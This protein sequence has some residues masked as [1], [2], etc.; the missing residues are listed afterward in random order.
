MPACA[1]GAAMP[2]RVVV[3][4]A[5]AVS[6]LGSSLEATWLALRAGSIAVAPITHFDA[7]G[8]ACRDA[9]VIPEHFLTEP[10]LSPREAR[11]LGGHGLA[12]LKAVRGALDDAALA[13]TGMPPERLGVFAGMGMVDPLPEDLAAAVSRS[14]GPAGLDLDAFLAEGYR[15]IHP[16]WP[17]GMLNNVAVCLVATRFG[18]LG[19]NTVLSSGP[20]AGLGA[21]L[22]AVAAVA[23]GRVQAAVAAAAAE[24]VSPF[25]AARRQRLDPSAGPPGEGAAALV[26]ELEGAALARDARVLAVVTQA[27]A[28]AGVPRADLEPL[29]GWGIGVRAALGDLGVAEPALTLALAAHAMGT[30]TSAAREHG[31][32][33]GAQRPE[34]RLQV[35]RG[36]RDPS[37]APRAQD[38]RVLLPA[39]PARPDRAAARDEGT[40][41][42]AVAAASRRGSARAG[43]PELTAASRRGSA[44]GE[45]LEVTAASRRG[46]ARGETLEVTAASRW[47]RVRAVALEGVG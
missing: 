35:P 14:S 7:S 6:A 43:T 30:G 31:H 8:F 27:G 24:P 15:E 2:D 19:A 1:W 20:D 47:G 37:P 42:V 22:E 34:D 26:L 32:P 23:E 9:A 41:L 33:E 10:D 25:S 5:G 46:S 45:T 18:L 29:A 44:R 12:L 38:D 36:E 11:I 13:G 17:L 39:S 21:F 28:G 3:T 4:G 40:S 16:L